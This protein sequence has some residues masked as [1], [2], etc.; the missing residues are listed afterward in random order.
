MKLTRHLQDRIE[1]DRSYIELDWIAQVIENPIER[2]I[3]PDG[4]IRFWGEAPYP[5]HENPHI[6]R[7]VTLED[8]E[9]VLTAFLD[10]GFIRRRR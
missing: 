9:T 5:D 10:S 1:R 2:E 6:L 3:Q 7:V 8:G 4:R